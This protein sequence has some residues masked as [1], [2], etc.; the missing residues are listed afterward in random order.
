MTTLLPTYLE[1]NNEGELENSSVQGLFG[2]F[3]VNLD[4]YIKIKFAFM[5]HMQISP[6]EI[7]N[8]PYWEYEEY[9]EL[10]SDVLKKKQDAEKGSGQHQSSMDPSREANKIMKSVKMPKFK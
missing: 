9:I 7:D 4:N 6:E 2:L 10:L 3:Q 8:W 5:Y 1:E